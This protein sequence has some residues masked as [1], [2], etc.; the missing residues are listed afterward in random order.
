MN[1]VVIFDLDCWF[2]GLGRL[3]NLKAFIDLSFE[4]GL[5]A[6]FSVGLWAL[7][8]KL[9]YIFT[10]FPWLSF[11]GG[12][13]G[14]LWRPG[15][16]RSYRYRFRWIW[17]VGWSLCVFWWIIVWAGCG[18]VALSFLGFIFRFH[19]LSSTSSVLTLGSERREA[20]IPLPFMIYNYI[21]IILNPK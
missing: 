5:C 4:E 12:R 16:G 13:A 20:P 8:A 21:Q 15:I 19:L 2:G 17:L 9:S 3:S 1:E 6:G 18:S 10:R 14:R 7:E 11:R